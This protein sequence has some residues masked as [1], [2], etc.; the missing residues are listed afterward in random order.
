MFAPARSRTANF[1]ISITVSSSRNPPATVVC[2][3]GF[4]RSMVLARSLRYHSPGACAGELTHRRNS[5]GTLLA[6]RLTGNM[7][8]ARVREW[9][10]TK[11]WVAVVLAT[12][13]LVLAGCGKPPAEDIAA[14]D[15]AL[16]EARSADA[17]EYAPESMKAAE[18]AR[19]QLDAE[20]KAQEE[21]FALFRSYDKATELATASKEAAARARTD[22]E[23]GKKRAREEAS[24]MIAQVR[25][26]ILEVQQLLD[27]APKGKGTEVD[28]AVLKSDLTG[29][30]NTLTEMDTAFAQEA[31]LESIAK[32]ESAKQNVDAIRGEIER[33]MELARSRRA[34]G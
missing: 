13:V 31:Y 18:D 22:A 9:T 11:K 16:G 3:S 14:A 24:E 19:A 33:A 7:R 20:L 1:V 23:E 5:E 10:M 6:S 32:A 34:R 8:G 30:E 28:L 26:S 17:V 4:L 25:A 2:R 21:K 27:Q 12:A 15:T 29:V